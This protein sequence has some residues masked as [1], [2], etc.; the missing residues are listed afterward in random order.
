[1]TRADDGALIELRSDGLHH[2][3]APVMAQL[4]GAEAVARDACFFRTG[5]RFCTGAPQ[6]LHL[7]KMLAL[8][9]GQRAAAQVTLDF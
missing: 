3:P 2:G 8:A 6:W 7:N 5:V 9:V 4:A 1:M